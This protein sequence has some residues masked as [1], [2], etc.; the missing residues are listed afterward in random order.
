MESEVEAAGVADVADVAG[1]ARALAQ[2]RLRRKVRS[3]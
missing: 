2:S 1:I 3:P